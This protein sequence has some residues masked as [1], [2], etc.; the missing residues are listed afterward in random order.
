MSKTM[1]RSLTSRFCTIFSAFQGSGKKKAIKVFVLAEKSY[2]SF[3]AID[4]HFLFNHTTMS[5]TPFWKSI[6][7]IDWF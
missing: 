6:W 4:G 5:L 3:V 1:P 2:K 7:S